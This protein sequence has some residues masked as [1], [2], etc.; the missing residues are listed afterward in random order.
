MLTLMMM[1]MENMITCLDSLDQCTYV[2]VY[3]G[4][5]LTDHQSRGVPRHILTHQF[6]FPELC[7][8]LYRPDRP[9]CG[10]WR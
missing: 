4:S 6:S 5:S 10:S 2:R 8:I 1:I 7:Q 3:V 9:G